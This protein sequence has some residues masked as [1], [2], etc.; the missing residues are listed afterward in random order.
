M[1]YRVK[2]R[3]EILDGMLATTLAQSNG[4]LTDT[5][6]GSVTRTTLDAASLQDADQYV[7]IARVKDKFSYRTCPD[8]ELDDRIADFMLIREPATQS[9]GLVTFS[10]TAITAAIRSTLSGIHLSGSAT[11]TLVNGSAFP[12]AGG[13]VVIERDVIG[14]RELIVY[15]SRT[16][17][18]LTLV[19]TTVYGH[20]TT[21]DVVLSTVGADRTFAI[22]TVGRVPETP[23]TAALDF[24][25]TAVAIILDGEA[26]SLAV[27]AV[28][29]ATGKVFNVAPLAISVLVAPLFPSAK[30]SNANVFTGGRDAE[31]GDELRSRIGERIQ[32]LKSSTINALSL[33]ALGV[34]LSSGLR[35]LY[36][37]D[38]EPANGVPDVILYVDDGTG[39]IAT[40]ASTATPETLAYNVASGKT[41]AVLLHWP[42]V[43]SSLHLHRDEY[44]GTLSV[45][46]PS[47]GFAGVG[48]GMAWGATSLVG[49]YLVDANGNVFLIT[50]NTNTS[51]TVVVVA[52]VN[53]IVG[54]YSVL[55][56][57]KLTSGTDYAFNETT[58]DIELVSGLSAGG[59]LVALAYTYYTGLIQETQRVINGDITDVE[60]YPG[61]KARGIKVVVSPVSYQAIT[62][63]ATVYTLTGVTSAS[64][65]P[66]VITAIEVYVNGLDIGA[67]VIFNELVAAVMA[68][69]GVVDVRFV[70][71][72]DNIAVLDSLLPRT[73]TAL[74]SIT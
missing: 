70:T 37:K 42:C 5:N 26:A 50:T 14:A 44:R 52:N 56:F 60:T 38:I 51:I 68:V 12:A 61:V 69:D 3:Q 59:A 15:S 45:V 64:V 47:P 7:Q 58:G 57:A 63:T 24:R 10:D 49:Q 19:G 40:T 9:V 39:S 74:I 17:N 53:P 71:P 6:R 4:A 35:V 54:A 43:A 21:A 30:V 23:T 22:G 34:S 62:V 36:A 66:S 2:T 65:I 1:A 11:L 67:P 46:T 16:G 18:I 55:Y 20:P 32:S 31:T 27:A 41:R 13:S 25:T 33:A 48:G 73:T 29:V 8:D 28:S 72:T